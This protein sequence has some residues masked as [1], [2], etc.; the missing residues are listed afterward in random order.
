MT[1]NSSKNI[2]DHIQIP[3]FEGKQS[4]E[5]SSTLIQN[6]KLR[7]N[8]EKLNIGK[9]INYS[10][11][12]LFL[13][14]TKRN[15]IVD[16]TKLKYDLFQ[17]IEFNLSKNAK[18]L[19]YLIAELN[20]INSDDDFYIED[21]CENNNKV[22]INK[23]L[24]L[25]E[26]YDFFF[27]FFN[28][29][30]IEN[31]TILKI[32]PYMY[33]M[34]LK[35]NEKIF[36]EGSSCSKLY[37]LLKG[38]I[39]FKKK[40]Y[41]GKDIE[42]FS[43]DK[44]GYNFG[45][46]ELINN[47]FHKYTAI[48]KETTYIIFIPKDIFIKYIRDKILKTESDIKK[49]IKNNL[50]QHLTISQ[51]KLE[52]FIESNVKN[53]YF[54]KNDIIFK[55]GEE[56]KNLYFIYKGEVDIIKDIGKGVDITFL[57]KDDSLSVESIQNKAKKINYKKIITKNI[58]NDEE[59]KNNYKLEISLE[60]N[61][62][63]I[64]AT[65]AKGCF[66]GLELTTG[67]NFFK[68]TYVCKSDFVMLLEINIE[69]LEE[70]LK[71]LM[72]NLMPYFFELEEKILKQT[73]NLTFFNYN[74]LPKSIQKFKTRNKYMKFWKYIDSLKIEDDEK[75]YLKQI[76]K[77]NNKF[78][79]NA[80]GFIIMNEQNMILQEHKN[81]LVDKIRDNY[82]KEKN[83][84]LYLNDFN[85]RKKV[86]LKSRNVKMTDNSK[87]KKNNILINLNKTR[88]FFKNRKTISYKLKFD[89]IEKIE[90]KKI[91]RNS[92]K[93]NTLDKFFNG[94]KSRNISSNNSYINV[95]I[96]KNYNLY[97]KE[98]KNDTNKKINIFKKNRKQYTNFMTLQRK[99]NDIKD[100]K[101]GLSLDCKNLIKKVCV[102]K[103][104]QNNF[105]DNNIYNFI[106]FKNKY[107]LNKSAS[108]SYKNNK[109]KIFEENNNNNNILLFD[110][111][112]SIKKEKKLNFYDTGNFDMPLATQLEKNSK[113]N[114]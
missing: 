70:H 90:K 96:N 16:L 114:I 34:I 1:N 85:K 2:N 25:L 83:F 95:K 33:P 15:S 112:L 13:K 9:N 42:E 106:K 67:I 53:Y 30:N 73:N 31:D 22:I 51:A 39:S 23:I 6:I 109:S 107:E 45:Q 17:N 36:N 75:S 4:N 58:I 44:E 104:E 71:E 77:I 28:R 78:D 56:T 18:D 110:N 74:L 102:K 19:L 21:N 52:R 38:K 32:I 76:N 8:F 86:F 79:I 12:S 69:N 48:C 91:V 40:S 89:S 81:L 11:S 84:E 82:Y 63:N 35:K 20:G 72:I 5:R 111:I 54:K 37:F 55:R 108:Y 66:I 10:S 26:N 99:K 43:I 14:K 3:S 27:F 105:N 87:E 57:T 41:Y 92:S 97:D 24:Y 113:Q 94:I 101:Q 64:M 98:I 65:L 7:Q 47:R 100:I 49:I 50:K 80:V 61:K 60:K 29:Y 62:Y 68:Y 46:W 88:S 103:D 59:S 93:K